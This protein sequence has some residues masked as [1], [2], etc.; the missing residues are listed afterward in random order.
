MNIVPSQQFN[1]LTPAQAERLFYLLEELGEAQQAIGKI[2]RH[3]YESRD[4]TK[5]R[6]TFDDNRGGQ[7]GWRNTSPTNRENLTS[8][9]GDVQRAIYML[10]EA[11]D[12]SEA[13]M[14]ATVAK[15][16]PT[17]YMHHQSVSQPVNT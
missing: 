1:G 15:G 3:G 4:P 2:L 6:Q 11:S 12:I 17:K 5:A 13:R 7:D 9:L 14:N 8:E 16:A 10:C